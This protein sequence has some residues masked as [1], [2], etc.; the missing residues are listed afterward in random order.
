MGFDFDRVVD[1]DGTASLK[2]DGRLDAYGSD[3]LPLWVADMDFP[4]PPAVL[5]ALEARVAHGVFGYPHVGAGFRAAVADWMARRHR[6]GVSPD[7]VVPTSGVVFD[8]NVALRAFTRPGEPVVIQPP[9]YGPFASAVS[10]NGRVPAGNPLVL[11]DGRYRMD[12]EGLGLAL[13][14]GARTAIF[15]SPHNPGGRVWTR[16]E[17]EAAAGLCLRHGA[18]IVCDEIHADLVLPGSRHVPIASLAPEISDRTITLGAPTKT[19]NIPGLSV[20]HAIIENPGLRKSFQDAMRREGVMG[21][22]SVLGIVALEAA[23]R[24]GAAWLDA[25]LLYIEENVRL[26]LERCR[27]WPITPMRP[28]GTY[29]VWLDCRELGLGDEALKRFMV[30]RAR[31]GLSA[32]SSYG[33]EGRRSEANRWTCG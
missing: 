20:S 29:L 30:E 9:V 19:F 23:Y 15:C 26:V 6:W 31:I 8:I 13:A 17:L 32:G 18:L 2:W 21:P 28:E 4:V 25:L 12:L 1:R 10:R 14:V 11:Q 7:W 16:G 27:P 5:R 24:D 22:H 3:V 33:E